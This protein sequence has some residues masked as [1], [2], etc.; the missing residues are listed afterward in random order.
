MRSLP[1]SESQ[2][3]GQ[4]I[5]L[6]RIEYKDHSASEITE[7]CRWWHLILICLM[8]F[9][10]KIY[11]NL[12]LSFNAVETASLV[13]ALTLLYDI[14]HQAQ[15]GDLLIQRLLGYHSPS[16]RILHP[17]QRAKDG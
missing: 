6:D 11:K 17:F 4:D 15:S 10:A 13:L 14:L 12:L 5:G 7:I 16:G 8:A 1:H 3:S 9:V 2:D